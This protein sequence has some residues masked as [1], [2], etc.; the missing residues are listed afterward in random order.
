MPYNTRR[1][2][3]DCWIRF[4]KCSILFFYYNTD[5]RIMECLQANRVFEIGMIT[6]FLIQMHAFSLQ[7]IMPVT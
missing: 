5:R 4:L 2:S 3:S 7:I 6:L 1:I